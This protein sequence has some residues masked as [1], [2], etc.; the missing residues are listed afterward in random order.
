MSRK[1]KQ[2][3]LKEKQYKKYFHLLALECAVL[4]YLVTSTFINQFRAEILYWTILFLAVAIK[5]YYLRP[6]ST[7]AQVRRAGNQMPV[8]VKGT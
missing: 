2:F 6:E 7:I 5:V 4:G 3:V 1:A 8:R